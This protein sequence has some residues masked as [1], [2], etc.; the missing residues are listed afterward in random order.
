MFIRFT[1]D[2]EHPLAF[3]QLNSFVLRYEI[4]YCDP[5]GTANESFIRSLNLYINGRLYNSAIDGEEQ[6]KLRSMYTYIVESLKAGSKI[7]TLNTNCLP[8][9]MKGVFPNA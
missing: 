8:P 6:D 7:C 5:F 3:E 9:F 2:N 4:E 1:D